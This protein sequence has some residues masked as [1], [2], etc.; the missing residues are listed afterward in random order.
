MPKPL[1]NRSTLDPRPST[2]PPVIHTVKEMAT[3]LHRSEDYV[4]DMKRGGF[5]LPATVEDAL[6]FIREKGPPTR[7]RLYK[8]RPSCRK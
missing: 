4:G 2:P 6:A 1:T 5:K 7:F 8:H 3:A